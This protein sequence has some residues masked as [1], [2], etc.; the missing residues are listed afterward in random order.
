MKSVLCFQMQT[1]PYSPED[2]IS[3]TAVFPVDL[4]QSEAD[5]E[6]RMDVWR[7]I[8]KVVEEYGELKMNNSL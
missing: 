7:K 6:L 5:S 4:N 3:S 1:V 2:Y 8:L